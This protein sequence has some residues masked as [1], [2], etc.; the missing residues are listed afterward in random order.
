[1]ISLIIMFVL[2][3]VY[4]LATWFS[5]RKSFSISDSF[6]NWSGPE[7]IYFIIMTWGISLPVLWLLPDHW[8][9]WLIV[10]GIASMVATGTFADFRASQVQRWLHNFGSYFG[11]GLTLLGIGFASTWLPMI[12]FLA[13]ALM[14]W[15]ITS[16]LGRYD[17][18]WWWEVAA[19]YV[20]WSHFLLELGKNT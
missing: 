12:I 5:S 3:T 7:R 19:F 18:I 20:I 15:G 17:R 8:G 1:M 11:I 9:Q 2:F 4:L 13:L 16:T 10:G 14:I 6:Y